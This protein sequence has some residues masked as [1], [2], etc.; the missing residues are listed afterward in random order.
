MQ[1]SLA[2]TAMISEFTTQGLAN[3]GLRWPT[4][5]CGHESVVST[6]YRIVLLQLLS[7]IVQL[8]V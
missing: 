4:V 5:T 3:R 8:Y 6:G 2:C 7:C 1:V